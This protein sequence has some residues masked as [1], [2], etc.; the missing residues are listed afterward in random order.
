MEMKGT[1]QG[2]KFMYLGYY[3]S[4][5][6]GSTQFLA[7]TGSSLVGKYKSEINDFLNGFVVQ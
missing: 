2:I 5:D 6:S 3:Y 4:D 1:L 7:Y